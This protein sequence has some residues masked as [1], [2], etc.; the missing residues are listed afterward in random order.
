VRD[1]SPLQHML[2]VIRG[3]IFGVDRFP[4]LEEKA[5][6]VAHA[7]M[8]GHVFMDGNKRTGTEVLF[9]MLE[10]NGH[11][12]LA[13]DDSIVE[14]IESVASGRATFD[15]FVIWARQHLR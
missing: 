12:L 13:S 6:A 4:T 14:I 7:I 5:C 15:D 3:A 9:T 10:L 2:D 1:P 8:R 11:T